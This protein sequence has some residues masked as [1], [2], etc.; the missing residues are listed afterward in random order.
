MLVDFRNCYDNRV[1]ADSYASLEFANTY[2]LA[3]RDLP[4]LVREHVAGTKALDF[5]CGTGRSTRFLRQLGLETMGIDIAP[6][7][8]AKARELDPEGDYCLAEPGDFSSM[9]S[10]AF[11]L[12]LCMF[13]FDNIAG[14]DVKLGLFRGLAGLLN[15]SGKL[16]NVVSSP[17]IYLHEWASF[18]T[19]E[20]PENRNASS[21]DVVRII[22]TDFADRTPAVDVLCTDESYRKLYC[23]AGLE[24]IAMHKPLAT[25]GEPYRW[26][27]ETQ[28]APW[29]IYVLGR[30]RG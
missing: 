23:D 11:D 19:K 6:D 21:G 4:A 13:P 15:D 26:V 22:T 24:V 14:F 10:R 25:G 16:I 27:S 3:F 17:E 1:R 7:M 12:I 18:T 2:Y 28:I 8:I 30:H 9:P 20:F 29:V 5:G